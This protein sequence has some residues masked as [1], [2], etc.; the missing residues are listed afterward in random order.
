MR[1]TK[2]TI[3]L[4]AATFEKLTRMAARHKQSLSL[5]GE[6]AI[7]AFVN[8]DETTAAQA[9]RLMRIERQIER[10]SR[11]SHI[12]V[13][14][15]TLFIW[16]WMVNNPPMPEQ[17]MLAAKAS[18]TERFDKFMEALGQRLA[19]GGVVDKALEDQTHLS[20]D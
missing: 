8:P 6:A 5:M 3:Y 16:N 13:E 17:S 2:L 4:E 11:D 1:K 9:R 18:A 10:L 14:T 12:A 7:G 15:L 19:G 20:L